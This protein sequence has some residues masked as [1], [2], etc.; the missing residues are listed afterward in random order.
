MKK[1]T[2]FVVFAVCSLYIAAQCKSPT[3]VHE[4]GVVSV[5]GYLQYE[6]YPC[7]ESDCPDCMVQALYNQQVHYY[8]T[9]NEFELPEEMRYRLVKIAIRGKEIN[10]G[11]VDWLSVEDWSLSDEPITTNL[12]TQ[13]SVVD[14]DKAGLENIQVIVSTEDESISDTVYAGSNGLFEVRSQNVPYPIQPMK[15][16]AKD[17]SGNYQT[18]TVIV[19]QYTYECGVDLVPEI[20][21]A[22]SEPIV[23]V[24][25]TAASALDKS[26]LPQIQAKT[27]RDGQLYIEREGKVYTVTGQE[28]TH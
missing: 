17:P 14:A 16:T 20:S 23:I 21:T 10:D 6:G 19:S 15:V 12:F 9:G 26:F 2:L 8:L 24:M 28:L 25:L 5:T 4:G 13:G 18:Q 11:H 22:E 3:I 1:F 7:F 27:I